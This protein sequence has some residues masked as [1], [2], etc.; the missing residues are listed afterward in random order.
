V[1][2]VEVTP[3]ATRPS[4]RSPSG[5]TRAQLVVEDVTVEAAD[6]VLAT[7]AWM[8]GGPAGDGMRV[9]FRI[10]GDGV[11]DT[12]ASP[13][14]P[15]AAVVAAWGGVDV[16]IDAPVDATA[17]DGARQAITMLAG[18]G[19]SAGATVPLIIATEVVAPASAPAEP[20]PAA[21]RGEA[22]SRAPCRA[23]A[24]AGAGAGSAAGAGAGSRRIG[25]FFTRGVDSTATLLTDA[26]EVTHLVGIDWVDPPYCSPGT[27]AV[28]ASTIAAAAER[29]LPLVRVTTNVRDLLDG[30]AGWRW[31][32]GPVLA[33]FGLA[34]APM[35]DE[36]R[37]SS[38][39][40]PG[41]STPNS[42]QERL[43]PLW[44]SSS[45]AVVHRAIGARLHR[46]A[47]VAADPWAMRWLK[48]CWMRPGDGNCG[49]CPKCLMTM[50]A[51]RICEADDLLATCF[52]E[53][54]TAEAV[55]DS[56]AVPR[57]SA[58]PLMAEL[59]DNLHPEDPLQAAWTLALTVA[60]D[61]Q[62]VEQ[63]SGSAGDTPGWS[64]H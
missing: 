48:V 63:A 52:D 41:D 21:G 23:G 53:P 54:L 38:A 51:L 10:H 20:F 27:E 15:V 24:G 1:Q 36:V 35:L 28:F 33:S 7:T 32:F 4:G 34:L 12:S 56:V 30:G 5:G 3:D 44:S 59:V 29:G 31:G 37:I 62:Q 16:V 45:V 42:S 64:G 57:V 58:I 14:L 19:H 61:A 13:F 11:L 22:F 9:R 55:V 46:T 49:R 50:T 17:L 6:G 18:F 47:I 39:F 26:S 2:N 60:C 8:R 25:L 43:D 40:S